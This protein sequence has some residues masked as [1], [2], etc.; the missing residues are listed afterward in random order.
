M[1]CIVLFFVLAVP[2]SDLKAQE[3]GLQKLDFLVGKWEAHASDSSF[4]SVLQYQFSPHKRL[5]MATNY[6]YNRE[7][8]LFATYEGAYLHEVDHLAYFIAGPGGETHRGT[9]DIKQKSVTHRA[10][11]FPGTRVKSYLSE[12]R[13]EDNRLLYYA[14]YSNEEDFPSSLDYSNPLVYIRKE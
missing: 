3:E 4:S 5:L 13:L 11:M 9:A 8:D 12:M 10:K 7:G 1:K 14:S 2:L 6:L